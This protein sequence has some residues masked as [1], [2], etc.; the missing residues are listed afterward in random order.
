MDLKIEGR[1]ALVTGASM[2]IGR[3]IARALAAE[4]VE[5][6]VAARR[7]ELLDELAAEIEAA[8]HTRAHVTPIDLFVTGAPAKLA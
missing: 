5:V 8:G 2:G 6:C 3:A 1:T 7:G 4:G